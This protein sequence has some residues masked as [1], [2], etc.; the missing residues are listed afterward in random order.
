[1]AVALSYFLFSHLTELGM[2]VEALGT[3]GRHALVTGAAGFIGFHLSRRL[4]SDGWRV[5]GV[6]NLNSYYDERLKRARLD[7]LKSEPGFDFHRTDI[8]DGHS[9]FSVFDAAD[10]EV[11]VN[12]AA[13]AGVRYSL[14]HPQEYVHSNL[15]GFTNVL[16]ACRHGNVRHLLYASSSSVYGANRETP[17]RTGMNVDHPM[18]LYAATKKA[19]ELMAHSYSHLYR[20]PTTGLRFFTVYGPWGRLD[21]AYYMFTKAILDGT[22]IKIFNHGDLYRDFTYV[23]DAIETVVRLIDLVPAGDTAWDGRMPD[24]SRSSA[25]YRI[26]NI[27]NERPVKL[28]EFIA[29][30]ENELGRKA[31]RESYPMQPGDMEIT[32]ADIE[33][34]ASLI[35]FTPSTPVEVGLKAFAAW[36][37]EFHGVG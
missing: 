10:P 12:L 34:L 1:M 37:R 23:D 20:L 11:V 8:A 6:D 21:M 17:F 30:L 19:N 33:N 28:A 3:T 4:L 7:R 9:L 22:P 13:Q 2:T 15:V 31:I 24:P 5:T 18:S 26:F 16:E 27:G 36:Y 35:E 14:E 29:V 32:F 25:P